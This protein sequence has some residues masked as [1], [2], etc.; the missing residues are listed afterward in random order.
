MNSRMKIPGQAQAGI[1]DGTGRT[2][3]LTEQR[4]FKRPSPRM[5]GVRPLGAIA[6]A[7]NRGGGCNE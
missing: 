2:P 7:G 4:P 3:C 6:L 1:P 5:R